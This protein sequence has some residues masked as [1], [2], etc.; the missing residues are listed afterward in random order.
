MRLDP[1]RVRRSYDTVAARYADEFVDELERK[2]LDRA[3]LSVVAD[4]VVQRGGGPVGDLGAGPGH[5]AS[6]LAGRGVDTVAL[7]LSPAMATIAHHRL[8]V[9]SVA[10]SLT[11]LPFGARALGG[12]VAFYCL[13]HLDE[14]AVEVAARELARVIVAGGPLLVAFHTGTEVRHLDSWHG[15]AVDLDFRFLEPGPVAAGLERAGFV[16]EA[17]LER[18]NYPDEGET[19]RTYVLARRRRP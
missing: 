17:V 4:D 19:R 7:D 9:A 10:G 3:L 11:A 16:V 6:F 18:Q 15:S 13:V 2:P 1:H 14:D 8:G 5:V 12:A